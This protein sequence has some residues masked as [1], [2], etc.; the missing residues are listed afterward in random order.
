M[1]LPWR[2]RSATRRIIVHS[3]H[4]PL[5]V[6]SHTDAMRAK[7]REMGLL[8]IGY[9][10]VI[11]PDGKLSECRPLHTIGSHTPGNNHDSIAVCLAG[12][13]ESG[14]TPDQLVTLQHFLLGLLRAFGRLPI[15]GHT[16]LQRYRNREL[17][18]P[19]MDMEAFRADFAQ[20]TRHLEIPDMDAQ[21]VTAQPVDGLTTQQR[22]VLDYLGA[23]RTLTTKIAVMS[24]GIMSISSRVAELRKLGHKILDEEAKDHFGKRYL[25]YRLQGAEA[26]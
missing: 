26:A 2:P 14:H 22:L 11:E 4:L 24:L 25:K 7:G 8:E 9:H 13:A 23:G 16:E 20:T 5:G 21:T 10:A 17:R 18:C 1:M 12:D 3:S 19:H 15:V 6:R